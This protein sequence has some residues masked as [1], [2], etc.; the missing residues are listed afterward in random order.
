M[1]PGAHARRTPNKPAV[2]MADGRSIGYAELEAAANRLAHLFRSAGLRRGDHIALVAENRPEL[3]VVVWAAQRSGL[4]YTLCSTLLNAEE[5][6]RIVDDCTA[7]VLIATDATIEVAQAVAAP[8]VERRL[9]IG[10]RRGAPAGWE[11][12][13]TALAGR[14]ATPI[15]DEAEGARMLYSSGTTGRPKGVKLPLPAEGYPHDPAGEAVAGLFGITHATVHLSPAPLYHAAPL[16]LALIVHRMG[17]TVVVQ[18]RFEPDELLRLI[19]R[20]RVTLTQLVPTMFV[21]LLRLPEGVRD[22]YDLSSLRAA[23]HTAAPCPV[24]VKERM[25]EWWGPVLHEYYTGTE[26]CGFVHCDSQEWLAHKGTV[27]RDVFDM[28]VHILGEDG[29][30]LPA[31]QAGTIYFE[32]LSGFEY[33]RDPERT[34]A[35]RDPRG[36]GWSTLGDIGYLDD[37]GFLYLTD[38]RAYVINSGGVNIYPQEA[39]NVLVLHPKVAD[40]AVFGIPDDEMGE[41]VHAV[42]EPVDGM[43]GSAELVA[44]L[45]SHCRERIAHYKCPRSIEFRSPLPRQPTGKLYKRLLRDEH[46]RGRSPVGPGDDRG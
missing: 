15:A 33:H 24:E 42:V 34:R 19:E 45:I 35:V 13:E 14:P 25:I 26:G 6:A 1:H 27:G 4:H 23:V 36:R 28:P 31:G 10:E 3:F 9:L 43:A 11:P 32:T 39:E 20:H 30:E 46:W 17:G 37:D 12:L 44:E 21:R 16:F 18:E 38:R 29:A 5:L 41:R 8:A 2:V 7:R 40:A 22:M